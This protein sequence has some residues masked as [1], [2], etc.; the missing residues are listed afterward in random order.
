ML[1][2]ILWLLQ[3]GAICQFVSLK[4]TKM[5]FKSLRRGYVVDDLRY[6][7]SNTWLDQFGMHVLN[8]TMMWQTPSSVSHA[9]L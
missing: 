3:V 7:T 9:A 8:S 6:L 4:A 2:L 5:S 1:D